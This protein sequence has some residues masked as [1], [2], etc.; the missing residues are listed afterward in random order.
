MIVKPFRGLRPRA[1]LAAQIPS[2][3]YDVLNSDEAR[4][5]AAG[6]PHTFLHVIKAE[7]D[8]EPGTA[9]S[10]ARV[11]AKAREN[12]QAMIERGWLVRDESPAYYVY[13]L[14]MDGR[15]Q[16]GILGAAAVDDYLQDRV[17]KHEHTRPDKETDRIQ[18][19]TSLNANPGPVFLTYRP[20]P[21][22][23][24][25]VSAITALAPDVEFTAPDSVEHSLWVITYLLIAIKQIP[26]NSL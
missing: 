11:Y 19:N 2:Q 20:L 4:A 24:A 13:R 21:E 3:P 22:L 23:N 15:A 25:M 9:S 6:D 26:S 10:D 16:T 12:L 7:I 5:L 17:K 1:D 18:L 14:V 8:L